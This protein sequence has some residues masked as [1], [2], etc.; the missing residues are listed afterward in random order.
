[1]GSRKK[2]AQPIS[3]RSL[4]EYRILGSGKL[5]ALILM[6][7]TPIGWKITGALTAKPL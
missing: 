7:I 3:R 6:S 2:Y 4:G 1:V 5:R